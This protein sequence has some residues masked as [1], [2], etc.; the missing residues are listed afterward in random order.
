MSALFYNLFCQVKS[1]QFYLIDSQNVFFFPPEIMNLFF[2][3]FIIYIQ[4][5]LLSK[6]K[7]TVNAKYWMSTLS[8]IASYLA[9][10]RFFWQVKK[11]QSVVAWLTLILA[12]EFVHRLSR[13]LTVEVE[14]L[15]GN[16]RQDLNLT[17]TTWNRA[18]QSNIIP[19][20]YTFKDKVESEQNKFNLN[21]KKS[22][23]QW[24]LVWLIWP[25]P[26]S[27]VKLQQNMVVCKLSFRMRVHVDIPV[28][29]WCVCCFL[30]VPILHDTT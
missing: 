7:C 13:N 28:T 15:I 21:E 14:E 10:W 19:I 2:V 16:R 3:P 9:V 22:S 4:V 20:A 5:K 23:C 18:K 11:N 6:K 25:T 12:G 24:L 8:W 17:E 1:K 26:R 29:Y 27:R 30:T